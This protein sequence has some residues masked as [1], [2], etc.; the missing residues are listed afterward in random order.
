MKKI[1]L[2]CVAIS[3]IFVVIAFSFPHIKCNSIGKK[4]NVEA[5]YSIDGGCEVKY[6]NEWLEIK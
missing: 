5:R 2:L 6:S 3:V 1:F 4:N